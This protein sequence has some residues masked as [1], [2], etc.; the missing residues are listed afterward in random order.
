MIFIDAYSQLEAGPFALPSLRSERYLQWLGAGAC[1]Q[2]ALRDAEKV[3]KLR[4]SWPKAY[5]RKAAAQTLV[6]FFN[7]VQS[8]KI[9]LP[10]K[11][12]TLVHF[13]ALLFFNLSFLLSIFSL[14][15]V[16]SLATTV[17]HGSLNRM[18]NLN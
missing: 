3:V 2:L 6:H 15:C 11:C 4:G 12:A 8:A 18:C 9:F 7:F 17:V 5:L 13:G 1:T 10:F 16:S 14:L